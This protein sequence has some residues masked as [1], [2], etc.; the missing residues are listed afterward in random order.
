MD[1][2]EE[3][4]T[5]MESLLPEQ[6]SKSIRSITLHFEKHSKEI[7]HT[8][9]EAF[10]K[11]VEQAAVLQDEK[12]KGKVRYILFSY[13]HSSIFLQRYLIRID[14]MD[15]TFYS[16]SSQAVS[17]WDARD[18]YQLFE[19]DVEAIREQLGKNYPRI[20]EYEADYIRYAYA[21][22]YHGVTKAF[23]QAMLEEALPE[24]NF[25]P[26][27]DRLESF[28]SILFGEYMGEA[29]ILFHIGEESI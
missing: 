23:L 2:K 17:Y 22:Y 11:A 6:L 5:A 14:L 12:K 13:L 18:I 21:P 4:M 7:V 25:L 16:D 3:L 26:Q 24:S 29:D 10:K 27:Q 19:G 8:F 15:H 9:L 28:V 20:R 1:R